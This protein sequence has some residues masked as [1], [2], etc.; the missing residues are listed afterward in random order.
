MPRINFVH[1]PKS[2]GTA[3]IAALRS[4]GVDCANRGHLPARQVSAEDRAGRITFSTVRSPWAWYL[5]WYLHGLQSETGKA[6]L[7]VYG[8]GSTTFDAVLRGATRPTQSRTPA[9]WGVIFGSSKTWDRNALLA[10]DRGL[11]SFS[12]DWLFGSQARDVDVLIHTDNL[13]QGLSALLGR[14]IEVDQVNVRRLS[15]LTSYYTAESA[16]WVAQA[17]SDLIRQHEWAPPFSEVS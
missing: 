11:Y 16:S 5:S 17:D 2:A 1:F 6:N 8:G 4:A 7:R 10:G 12:H 14:P 15:P 13:T 9:Q 3:V